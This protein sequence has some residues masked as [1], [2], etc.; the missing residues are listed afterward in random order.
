MSL[1][2]DAAEY[3]SRE[4]GI[5]P[6]FVEKDWHAVRVLGALSRH[7]YGSVTT[8]FTGGTS[9][10][11]G[12]DLLKRF[13]EDLDFRARFEGN[14][15]ANQLKKLKSAFR[16]SVIEALR[17]IEGIAFDEEGIEKDGLGFKIQLTYPKVFEAPEGIRAELQVEFSYTQPRLEPEQRSIASMI[18][19]YKG[20]ADE[21]SFLCLSPVEIAADKFSSLVWR[22]LKRNRD[23]EKDDPAMIRHL[24]DLCALKGRIQA[25]QDLFIATAL[26][27]FAIDQERVNRRV[28]MELGEASKHA[29]D[30]LKSDDLYEEEYQQFV[31]AMSYARDDE[32]ISFEKAL[33]EF[34]ALLK[35]FS[36]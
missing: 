11:K 8:I 35:M 13:S 31:D 2:K 15:S 24:H 9:L 19:S 36:K 10:S 27:S 25:E 17:E 29:A 28:E 3:L 18:T 22:V 33:N 7:S 1:D 4:Q 21:T 30:K 5:D 12:H 34:D 26:E 16:F 23:D 20:E 6:A 14:F 32:V